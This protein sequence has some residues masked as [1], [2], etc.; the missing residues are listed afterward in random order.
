LNKIA[1]VAF[2]L[3]GCYLRNNYHGANVKTKALVGSMVL[4]GSGIR[5]I[6]MVLKISTGCL[7]YEM[8]F[9]QT[10]GLC[11]KGSY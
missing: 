5:D 2:T 10:E 11:F 9:K 7:H 8:W 6:H 1:V 3:T 4:N